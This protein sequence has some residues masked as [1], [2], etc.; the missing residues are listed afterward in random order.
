MDE[1]IIYPTIAL[2]VLA[3]ISYLVVCRSQ[4]KE[5]NVAVLVNLILAASGVCCG[6]ILMASTFY[7]PLRDRVSGLSLYV[8]IAGLVVF[9]VSAQAIRREIVAK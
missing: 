3:V 7:E 4:K 9:F 8:F 2:G 1:L 6:V 5:A